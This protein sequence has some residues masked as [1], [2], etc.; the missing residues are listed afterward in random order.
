MYVKPGSVFVTFRT[1][2]TPLTSSVY[3][4]V[5]N[6]LVGAVIDKDGK[7][8]AYDEFDRQV[9]ESEVRDA[10]GDRMEE[11][12]ILAELSLDPLIPIHGIAET[13]LRSGANVAGVNGSKERL[14]DIAVRIM[15]NGETPVRLLSI[16]RSRYPED[17]EKIIGGGGMA[18]DMG[19]LG[20]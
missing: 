9:R 10:I 12:K 7:G 18:A 2:R 6:A 20:F 8:V 4:A 15:A 16:L 3:K 17:Y 13:L 19:D 5:V 11:V 1:V 14:F